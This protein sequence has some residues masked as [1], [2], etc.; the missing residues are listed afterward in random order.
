MEVKYV[1][2]VRL[3]VA[4]ERINFANESE[5]IALLHKQ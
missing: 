1:R 4:R 5:F 3:S 2:Q